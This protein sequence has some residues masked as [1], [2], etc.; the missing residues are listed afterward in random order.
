MIWQTIRKMKNIVFLFKF[1]LRVYTQKEC[2]EA[3][4]NMLHFKRG[5]NKFS[6]YKFDK[7]KP[8][9][10]YIPVTNIKYNLK[11]KI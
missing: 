8:I 1:H 7:Q 9:V 3:P 2:K 10:F 5:L 11:D 6:K 4:N